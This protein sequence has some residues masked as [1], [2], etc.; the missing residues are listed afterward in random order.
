MAE[1]RRMKRKLRIEIGVKN[2]EKPGVCE[3]RE[4]PKGRAPELMDQKRG[5]NSHGG[6]E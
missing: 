4:T 6:V 2:A 5:V 1:N 3:N